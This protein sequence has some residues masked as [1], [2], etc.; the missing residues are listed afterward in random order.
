MIKPRTGKK[1]NKI[2]AVTPGQQAVFYDNG[3]LLGGGV[4]ENTYIDGEDLALKLNN[5]VNHGK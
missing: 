4:I 2:K 5:R 1:P 3:K